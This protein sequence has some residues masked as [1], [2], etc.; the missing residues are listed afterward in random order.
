[1]I[2]ESKSYPAGTQIIM[3]LDQF[4]QNSA[5]DPQTW[6]DPGLKNPFDGLVFGAGKRTC[7]GKTIAKSLM[8]EMLKSM[9][10]LVPDLKIQPGIHHLY[11]GRDND[12]KV[13]FRESLYQIRIFGRALWRS[14]KI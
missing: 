6:L 12:S 5:F 7:L 14:F 1:M 8:V 2:I 9:L 10:I 4:V 3:I 13:S 11:S